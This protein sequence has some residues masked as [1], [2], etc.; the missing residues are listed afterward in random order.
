MLDVGCGEGLLT[1]A[2][3]A[4]AQHVVGIDVDA[5]TLDLARRDAPA[6]NLEYV[7]GDF[8]NDESCPPASSL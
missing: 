5:A 1:L 2:L 7:L 8:L 4:R 6:P 3:A